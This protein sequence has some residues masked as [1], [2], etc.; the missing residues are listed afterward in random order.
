MLQA[1]RLGES[2]RVNVMS[3]FHN[4]R[5]LLLKLTQETMAYP[6]S[7]LLR[8]LCSELSAS[9]CMLF[10]NEADLEI[11]LSNPQSLLVTFGTSARNGTQVS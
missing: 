11:Q 1:P 8:F 4:P 3:E 2:L 7:Q 9:K 5:M 6:Q 10:S